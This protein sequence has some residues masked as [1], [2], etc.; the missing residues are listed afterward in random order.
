MLNKKGG[1]GHVLKHHRGRHE[2]RKMVRVLRILR[3]KRGVKWGEHAVLHRGYMRVM[4]RGKR[5]VVHR[6]AV[7]IIHHG[8]RVC[9]WREPILRVVKEGGMWERGVEGG[10]VHHVHES[11]RWERRGGAA[12][13]VRLVAVR[14][15]DR[16][17]LAARPLGSIVASVSD[18]SLYAALTRELVVTRLVLLAA[19]VT[20]I[21]KHE[22]F[23]FESDIGDWRW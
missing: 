11:F 13:R 22:L 16:G 12:L 6:V 15:G 5:M 17:V 4:G 18:A 14:G 7:R 23:C 8:R 10:G 19:P 2:G 1:R 3:V 20:S 21:S 9:H